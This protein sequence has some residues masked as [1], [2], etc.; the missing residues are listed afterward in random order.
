MLV[1]EKAKKSFSTTERREK[2][3]WCMYDFAKSAFESVLGVFMGP[4]MTY[5]AQKQ[6]CITNSHDCSWCETSSSCISDFYPVLG[7]MTQTPCERS[8]CWQETELCCE[9]GGQFVLLAGTPIAYAAFF[10][11]ITSA[12]VIFQVICLPLFGALGDAYNPKRFLIGSTVIAAGSL[13]AMFGTNSPDRFWVVGLLCI[14]ANVAYG[15]TGIFYNASLLY[16]ATADEADDLSSRGF[17]VG[18]IGSVLFLV[19]C[20]LVYSKSPGIP[21]TILLIALTGIWWLVWAIIPFLFVKSSTPRGS[22]DFGAEHRIRN[23]TGNVFV[24]A[25]R[26]FGA[27]IRIL[28][29]TPHTAL[30]LAASAIYNDGI[31][32]ISGQAAVYATSTV[33]AES[34][35]LL[36]VVL[37]INVTAILGALLF[38]KLSQKIKSTKLAIFLGLV[39]FMAVVIYSY[40]IQRTVELWFIGVLIGFGVGGTQSLSRSLLAVMIPLNFENEIFSFYEITQRGTSWIGPIVYGA[41]T[42]AYVNNQ[43]PAMLSMIM[44]LVIGGILLL[45]VNVEKAKEQA[46]NCQQGISVGDDI[47]S[48]SSGSP[49]SPNSELDY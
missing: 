30:F 33:H 44:F 13:I 24:R 39:V 28:A 12:S 45:L 2:W 3:A 11:F 35:Q 32:T 42:T 15:V 49:I 26:K 31:A 38:N 37:I 1:W 40:F 16:V 46:A 21:T 7:N 36:L 23:T 5:L 10:S 9:D 20:L 19:V 41:F 43:R 34:S 27:A 4:Y 18:Y 22:A 14:I 8:S 48:S 29:K 6:A 25:G 17:A 47:S